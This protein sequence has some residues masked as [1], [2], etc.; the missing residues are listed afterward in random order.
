MFFLNLICNFYC[1]TYTSD[2]Q[3]QLYE[4]QALNMQPSTFILPVLKFKFFLN[5]IRKLLTLKAIYCS[6]FHFVYVYTE[7][8]GREMLLH[9]IHALN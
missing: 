5:F 2:I 9:K 7:M 1:F 3:P 6:Y 8:R 4:S